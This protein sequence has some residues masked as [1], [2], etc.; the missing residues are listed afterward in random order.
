MGLWA[1]IYLGKR[2]NI[3]SWIVGSNAWDCGQ[4]FIWAREEI[5]S[6]RLLEVWYGYVGRFLLGKRRN[7]RPWI[8]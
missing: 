1:D 4:V 8:V 5:H 6:H 7:T 2:R 3:R